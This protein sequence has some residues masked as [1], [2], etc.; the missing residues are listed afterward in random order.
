MVKIAPRP[1]P[2]LVR[3]DRAPVQFDKVFDNREAQSKAAESSRDRLVRLLE[4]GSKMCG[5]EIRFDADPRIGDR[6]LGVRNRIA[7]A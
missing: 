5:K 1:S 6:N 7:A 4:T 2:G 3:A